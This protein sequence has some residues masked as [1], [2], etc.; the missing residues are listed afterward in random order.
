MNGM[1]PDGKNVNFGDLGA[2]PAIDFWNS[3]LSAF[4]ALSQRQ[5]LDSADLF[6]RAVTGQ[7]SLDQWVRDLIAMW[8]RWFSL[9]NLP[10]EWLAR[11][12]SQV[13]L[14]VFVVDQEAETDIRSVRPPVVLTS[15]Q[16]EVTDLWN[17]QGNNS[18]L[19]NQPGKQCINV[20]LTQD[21]N[22]LDVRLVSLLQQR[23]DPGLYIGAVYA[24]AP[25][26]ATRYLLALVL[27]LAPLARP[28][29]EVAPPPPGTV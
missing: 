5:M 20:E 27:V 9:A 8:M 7:F 16:L 28:R 6:Q 3:L 15:A 29:A 1:P 17:I 13:P 24:H 26:E 10:M 25:P 2:N 23:L 12:T 21:G 11:S 18:K 14:A 22:R 4:T 19:E